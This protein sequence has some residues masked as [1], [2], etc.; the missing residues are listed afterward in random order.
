M[1]G[2]S[3][4]LSLNIDVNSAKEKVASMVASQRHRGP[5]D[6]G[7]FTECK[8]N[9]TVSLGHNRLSIIDITSDG[10]QPMTDDIT[11]N[12]VVYNGEIYNFIEIRKELI[13]LGYSFKSRTDTEVILKSYAEWGIDCVERFRGIFAFALWDSKEQK[14]ILAR[15]QMGVKPLYYYINNKSVYFA[16]EVRALMA[17]GISRYISK[18]GL[19]S[20]ISYGSVQEPFTLIDG[21]YSLVPGCM[22]VIDSQIKIKIERY[23]NPAFAISSTNHVKEAEQEVSRLLE[24]SV[25]IQLV[26]DVPLGAFLSGGIDSSAI[27]ALMRKVEPDADLHTFSIIFDDP[28]YDEREYARLVAKQNRTKHTELLMTGQFIQNSLK[29][30]I[31][32][33]DQPSM[34]GM[35][36][37]CVSK[38]VK[39]SGITVALS[40]VGGD[41]LFV[42]YGNFSK[43]LQM[44]RYHNMLKFIPNTLASGLD[45]VAQNEKVRKACELI[46]EDFDPYFV[47]RR[48]FSDSQ[49]D[50]L[51]KPELKRK[52]N[53][54]MEQSYSG[55]IDKEYIDNICKIS[56]FEQ[57]SYMLSTLLRDTDQMSM[58]HS[59]EIRVPLIDHKL[60]EYVTAIPKELKVEAKI[61]KHL[62]VK[63]AGNGIPNE[64]IFRAKRGFSF[65]FE[66]YLVKDMR[67][68][69]L[70]FVN[71]G[72]LLYNG[73]YLREMW[74]QFEKGNLGWARILII[75]LTECWVKEWNVQT[76]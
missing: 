71:G 75:Y 37:W 16:S 73:R 42:G 53:L 76:K 23:W 34:D 67:D 21:C 69:I 22:M 30:I 19:A 54:W 27:V 65:P 12:V 29:S 50:K 46:K 39:E 24:E 14:L 43:A 70:H 60:V 25:K 33:Y 44:Y 18:D 9:V 59:L 38:L 57:R 45:S 5:D 4:I 8:N 63:A 68:D 61:P 1:C 7:S 10:H 52:R 58:N 36:S 47:D 20:I 26:S 62:L 3:G 72:S 15:D 51:L 28:K 11:K 35:N 48:V 49:Y 40:G 56:W 17:G 13:S 55:M 2:I 66:K 32:A 6:E 64:C 41:E 74:S 31:S